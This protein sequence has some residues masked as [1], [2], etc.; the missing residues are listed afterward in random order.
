MVLILMAAIIVIISYKYYHIN[1]QHARTDYYENELL[2]A[3]LLHT[4][5]S[6]E[7]AS[8]YQRIDSLLMK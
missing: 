2:N 7:I 4:S 3:S 8:Q 5:D 1:Q 6:I